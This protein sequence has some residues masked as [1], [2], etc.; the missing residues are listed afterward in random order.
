MIY[1]KDV[2]P[3]WCDLEVALGGGLG[4]GWEVAGLCCDP[5]LGFRTGLPLVLVDKPGFAP[6]ATLDQLLFAT[7]QG[8]CQFCA[9]SGGFEVHV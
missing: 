3:S 8:W 9:L 5:G 7:P 4:F 2:K 1:G 6:H